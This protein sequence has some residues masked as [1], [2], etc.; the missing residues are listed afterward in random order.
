[1]PTLLHISDLHRTSQPQLSNDELLTAIV[2]D[3]GRWVS[4]GIPDPDLIVV[5]GDLIQGAGSHIA[6][7]DSE[8][9]TQYAE[10][11]DFL[12]N[13]A[14]AF[15]DSDL[16]RVIVVPGNHDVHWGRSRRAMRPLD[17][18]PDRLASM[19]FE[20]KS[21]IRWDWSKQQA[22]EICDGDVYESRFENFRQFQAEF[23]AG[24]DRNP[25]SHGYEDIVFVEY[26]ELGIVI[27]GFSS[28]HGNDCFCHVG[29]IDSASLASSQ[30]LLADANAPIAVAVWHHNVLGGPR[31]HDYMD[32]R[33]IHKLIDLGFSLGLHG[34][35]HYPGAAPFKLHLPNL[36]SMAV[37]GAGSIAASDSDLPM[38]E[39]RQF[40]II[41]VDPCR[42]SITVHVRAMSP[43]GIFT[44][45]HRDDFGGNSYIELGIEH[46]PARPKGPTAVQQL[47]DA[48]TAVASGEFEKALG[49]LQEIGPHDS[50]YEMR[51]ISIN[52]LEG[53]ERF[54]ELIVLL[55]PP[56]NSYE[57]VRLISLLLNDHLFD[58]ATAQLEAASALLDDSLVE[59]LGA[60]I[61][62]RRMMS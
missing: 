45:S 1:M 7:P 15:V 42:E 14:A 43:A 18:S 26:P 5:S 47:D 51:Q 9:V 6:D 48:M 55:D 12:M 36:T 4:E 19:A 24:L 40:N 25:M 44:A 57:A 10:A 23:Y 17:E 60:M 35:Q 46:S 61:A 13:L 8:I 53:L 49:Y 21:M 2:S 28:L 31:A 16:S 52:A 20:A 58:E 37:V 30:S 34:H 33:S 62:G 3:A 29:E 50:S 56:Q 11:A 41:V 22:Y 32:H 27:V 59:E 39:P 38:G 54:D